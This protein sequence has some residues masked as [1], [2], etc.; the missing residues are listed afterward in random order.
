MMSLNVAALL[1]QSSRAI[2]WN[3]AENFVQVDTNPATSGLNVSSDSTLICAGPPRV[4]D[5][6]SVLKLGLAPSFSVSQQIPQNRIAEIGSRRVHIINGTP[7]GG[8]SISRFLYN[9]P[10]LFRMSY[11]LIFDNDGRLL[12]SAKESLRL[13]SGNDQDALIRLWENMV[14]LNS[15][16]VKGHS[17]TNFWISTW[18]DK[19]KFPIGFAIYHQDTAGNYVGGY[20]IE[21]VK[22]NMHGISQQAGQMVLAESLSFAFD[23][24]IPIADGPAVRR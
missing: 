16:I 6:F 8:G 20:Y 12:D 23:R 14:G 1:S 4:S 15:R 2:D 3:W 9:G 7:V 11:G 21:G 10:T 13:E 22:Y 24:I 19:A 18:D 17:K 5:A